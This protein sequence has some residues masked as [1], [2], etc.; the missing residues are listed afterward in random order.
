MLMRAPN[1]SNRSAER[2]DVAKEGGMAILLCGW[3]WLEIGY[4][5]RR[6]CRV[7]LDITYYLYSVLKWIFGT[8]PSG[9]TGGCSTLPAKPTLSPH[10]R[11]F[12]PQ[13]HPIVPF[14]QRRLHL[15]QSRQSHHL[16]L[17]PRIRLRCCGY[18]PGGRPSGNARERGDMNKLEQAFCNKQV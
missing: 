4:S 18:H 16:P 3:M 14:G 12:L 13:W 15:L 8:S 9:V 5:Y 6:C 1:V 7:W 10:W 2:T 11:L 17:Q